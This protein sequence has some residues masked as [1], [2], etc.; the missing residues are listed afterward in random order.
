M[1]P[2]VVYNAAAISAG[3]SKRECIFQ[4]CQPLH[5]RFQLLRLARAAESN[6]SQTNDARCNSS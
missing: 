1:L 6:K 4:N 3:H 2:C 5:R